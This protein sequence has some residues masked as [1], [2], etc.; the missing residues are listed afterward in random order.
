MTDATEKGR[1]AGVDTIAL[2]IT[3]PHRTKRTVRNVGNSLFDVKQKEVLLR[4]DKQRQV[5]C[6]QHGLYNGA[7]TACG[8]CVDCF[9]RKQTRLKGRC[10]A[11]AY[12]SQHSIFWTGTY[13]DERLANDPPKKQHVEDFVKVVRRVVGCRALVVYERGDKTDRPHWHAL[14]FLRGPVPEGIPLDYAGKHL[15]GP[16]ADRLGKFPDQSLALS[17]TLWTTSTRAA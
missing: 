2:S 17:D 9:T 6:K 13:T 14:L 7:R 1:K 15:G 16:R 3:T 10:A 8:G 5:S 12:T 4:T 11:E